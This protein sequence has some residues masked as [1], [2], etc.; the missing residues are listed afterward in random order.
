MTGITRQSLIKVKPLHSMA[1]SDMQN[2]GRVLAQQRRKLKRLYNQ[3]RKMF[4]EL[5]YTKEDLKV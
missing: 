4:F 3:N 5:G 2:I 1:Y